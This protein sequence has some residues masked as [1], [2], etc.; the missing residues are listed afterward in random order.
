MML[1]LPNNQQSEPQ[2]LLLKH[3]DLNRE[4]DMVSKVWSLDNNSS[5]LHALSLYNPFGVIASLMSP[6]SVGGKVVILPQ[7]DTCK[8]S[9]TF[10]L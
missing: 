7:F 6:L 8:V 2:R 3:K 9:T 10:K 4:M 5:L 1:Y